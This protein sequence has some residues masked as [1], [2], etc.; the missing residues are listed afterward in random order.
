MFSK[1]EIADILFLDIETVRLTHT[2]EEL[3]EGLMK[4]W[5]HKCEYLKGEETAEEKYYSQAGIYAEFG[6]IVCI[7]C[8]FIKWE[9]DEPVFRVKSFCDEDEKALLL[10][11]K[12]LLN[13][14]AGEKRLCAHNGKEFDFPY[15]CRRYLINQLH[16]PKPL[17]IQNKKPWEITHLDTMELWKFGDKKAPTKLELLCN[18]FGIPTP[19]DDIDGSLV[20]QVFWSEKD[21]DRIARYCEKD[22]VATAQLLLKYAIL[23]CIPESQ[24]ALIH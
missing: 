19:K 21:L 13:G 12:N 18:I 2:Y 6:K 16:L 10:D 1:Q 15:L 3:P 11:F 20:S 24:V 9:G 22:V 14:K 17:E 5:E 7:S 4:M 8:G 23:P